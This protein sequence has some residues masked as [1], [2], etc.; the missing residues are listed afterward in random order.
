[1]DSLKNLTSLSLIIIL[2][3]VF[4]YLITAIIY[5]K[6]DKWVVPSGDP[7][8]Y[9]ISLFELLD[10]SRDNYWDG[11]F[12]GVFNQQWYWLYKL[13]VAILSPFLAKEPYILC[14]VNYLFMAVG[15]ISFSRLSL[16]LG[17]N[18]NRT[19]ILTLSLWLYPWI[20]GTHTNLSLFT[21]MLDTSFYWILIAFTSHVTLYAL[22]PQNIKNGLI[23]GIFAGL[24][25][26]GRGNSLPYVIIILL[27]PMTLIGYRWI[28]SPRHTKQYLFPMV[29]FIGT[30]TIMAAWYYSLTF[31][32][33]RIYYW[34]WD[35][36]GTCG[37]SLSLFKNLETTLAG[38]KY[39]LIN[40]PGAL[41]FRYP[42]SFWSILSTALMHGLV[43]WSLAGAILKWKK[44]PSTTSHLL[45]ISSITGTLLFYGNL[46]MMVVILAPSLG[47]DPVEIYHPFL[48]MLVGFAFALLGPLVTLTGKT[49]FNNWTERPV[50][51]PL[52]MIFIL[53]YGYVATKTLTPDYIWPKTATP[54]D[55]SQFATKLENH[56]GDSSISILWYGQAYNRFILD[57]YRLKYG[58]PGANF[59]TGREQISLLT[60][61]Y[62]DQCAENIPME[63]FRK[64]L[65]KIMRRSDYIIIPED[66]RKFEFM[67]GQPGLAN[68]REEL[69]KFL[70][71]SESPQYGVKMILHDHYD[72]RLLLLKRLKFD[73]NPDHLDLLK[74]PYGSKHAK[75]PQPYPNALSDTFTPSPK[76]PFPVRNLS[77]SSWDVFWE[78]KGSYPHEIMVD[79]DDPKKLAGYI[80]KVGKYGADDTSR[81]PS[82]WKLE[83]ST[84]GKRWTTLDSRFDQ[85]Q[86]QEREKRTFHVQSPGEYLYNR[87]VFHK[88]LNN[89]II[90]ISEIELLAQNPNGKISVLEYQWE[91]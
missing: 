24:A 49:A 55:V 22:E 69:A 62:T 87:F 65:R 67:L 56:I 63:D 33:L 20:Y 38:I 44:Q 57:Y 16:R 86:W 85:T 88:G 47:A 83:G 25:I 42:Y 1:M 13:P 76:N 28:K 31:E 8:S 2:L 6:F 7:F 34:D 18:F 17:L 74:L 51:L 90:R 61:A 9:T 75:Y 39:I 36:T 64:L 81:M 70:N 59:Y 50:A 11:I 3:S 26:W 72:T 79:F 14:F 23:A 54:N 68:R 78:K 53:S 40:F 43:L 52:I 4:L 41:I 73:K 48:M 15:T 58:L 60:T 80:F 84:D 19:L 12:S 5:F 30:T 71:S 45:A 91:Q 82:D 66:I 37:D 32:G 89:R 35:Q 29:A 10:Y 77:H 27:A 46:L 21:L